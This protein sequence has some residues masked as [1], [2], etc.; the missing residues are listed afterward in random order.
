MGNSNYK[1]LENNNKITNQNLGNID[2]F[3]VPKNIKELFVTKKIIN[4]EKKNHIINDHIINRDKKEDDKNLDMYPLVIDYNLMKTMKDCELCLFFQKIGIEKNLNILDVDR[5]IDFL[6]KENKIISLEYIINTII[7]Y[8][9]NEQIL[10][11]INKKFNYE[12]FNNLQYMNSQHADTI[13][14]NLALLLICLGKNLDEYIVTLDNYVYDALLYRLIYLEDYHTRYK[15][16]KHVIEKKTISI[17]LPLIY[18]H[19][20]TNGVDE[21]L[22]ML[23][24]HFWKDQNKI[25]NLLLFQFKYFYDIVLN[26]FEIIDFNNHVYKYVGENLDF[27]LKDKNKEKIKMYLQKFINNPKIYIENCIHSGNVELLNCFDLNNKNN[28]NVINEYYHK[29]KK[30]IKNLKLKN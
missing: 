18:D 15:I 24:I 6:L 2:D 27:K 4:D 7:N 12:F 11:L 30:L 3:K 23:V 9:T 25:S 5:I 21:V 20:I 8:G 1:L 19:Y 28:I 17:E 26:N 13:I 16:V 22:K 29:K 14:V 10:F